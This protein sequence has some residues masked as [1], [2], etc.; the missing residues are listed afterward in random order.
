ML[1]DRIH[2]IHWLFF[3]KSILYASC[4]AGRRGEADLN[5]PHHLSS[6]V[7]PF[8]LSPRESKEFLLLLGSQYLLFSL[9]PVHN[10]VNSPFIPVSLGELSE[11][12]SV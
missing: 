10:S 3:S 2:Y 12:N 9:N 11:V 7:V 5:G 8:S 1:G 4:P 6:S